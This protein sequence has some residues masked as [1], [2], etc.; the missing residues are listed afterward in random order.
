MA[1]KGQYIAGYI[2]LQW[3]SKYR[4]FHEKGIPEIMDLNVFPPFRGEGIGSKLMDI[5]EKE[6]Q[7]KSST[8]GIGVGLY[9]DYGPAQRM[10][11]KRG[12]T[13]DV[14]GVTYDYGPVKPG[15]KVPL[16]G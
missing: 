9:V 2:T 14:R 6:A 7:A 8:L 3:D 5:V 15:K 10:Y 16:D 13:P 11:I 12:H 4:S 1:S